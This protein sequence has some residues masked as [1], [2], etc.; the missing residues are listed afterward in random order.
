MRQRAQHPL[1]DS[2]WGRRRPGPL[3]RAADCRPG[4]LGRPAT[5]APPS[6]GITIESALNVEIDNNEISGWRSS[7]IQVMDNALPPRICHMEGAPDCGQRNS[8]TIRIRANYIHHNQQNGT[9]GYGVAVVKGAYALIEKNV[10]DYNRHAIATD[11]STG[12]GYL[13]YRNLVLEHGGFHENAGIT[14]YTHQFDIHGTSDCDA[15]LWIDGHHNCGP[16]GDTRRFTSTAS[17]TRATTPSSCAEPRAS[18]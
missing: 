8:S 3:H 13:A 1:P 9:D 2:R 11:G 17:S 12:S 14:I 4:D 15:F 18:A 16:A 10:F 7:A 6:H 5:V